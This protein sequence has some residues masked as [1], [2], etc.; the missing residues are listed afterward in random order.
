[1]TDFDF[2]NRYHSHVLFTATAFEL[3]P[4]FSMFRKTVEL[5]GIDFPGQAGSYEWMRV[6]MTLMFSPRTGIPDFKCS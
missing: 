3:G 4:Q 2:I 6:L 5:K 1:M